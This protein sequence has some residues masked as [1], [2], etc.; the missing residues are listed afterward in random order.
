MVEIGN[1]EAGIVAAAEAIAIY[2]EKPEFNSVTQLNPVVIEENV[3]SL[4]L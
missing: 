1:M 2:L 4:M 3:N